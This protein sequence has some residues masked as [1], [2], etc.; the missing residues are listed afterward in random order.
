MYGYII[1]HYFSFE[2]KN[3]AV[4]CENYRKMRV[5]CGD[6][7]QSYVLSVKAVPTIINIHKN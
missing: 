5:N 6:K 2:I 1:M 3:V 4:Y 7:M